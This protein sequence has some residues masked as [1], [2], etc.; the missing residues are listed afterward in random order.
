VTPDQIYSVTWITAWTVAAV[1]LV[2]I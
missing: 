2:M 1:A